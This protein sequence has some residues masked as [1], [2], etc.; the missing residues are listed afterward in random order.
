MIASAGIAVSA[1][2]VSALPIPGNHYFRTRFTQKVT[3]P[4]CVMR[5]T[6]TRKPRNTRKQLPRW[7]IHR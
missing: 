5:S 1:A 6:R 4:A 3:F 2:F 7:P